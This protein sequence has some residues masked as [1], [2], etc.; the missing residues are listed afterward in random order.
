MIGVRK[1]VVVDAVAL[2]AYLAAS[3]PSITGVAFHEWL[4]IGVFVILIVHCVQHYDWIFDTLKGFTKM[5]S[6]A[7][8]ARL[9]LD[10]LIAV[11]LVV[12]MVSGVLI[13]GAVL[14]TLGLFAGGYYLWDPL[15][16]ASAKVL[17]ALLLLHLAVNFGVVVRH[18]KRGS[19]VVSGQKDSTV[20]EL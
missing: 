15:H 8:R 13:S 1:A 16:I 7:R 10:V 17:L 19:T 6:F 4:S 2:I 14:P 18:L 11:A 9:I 3:F 20:D 12:V 5:K